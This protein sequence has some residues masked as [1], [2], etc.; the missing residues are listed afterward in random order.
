MPCTLVIRR[1]AA[2]YGRA[3]SRRL[4][5]QRQY[6]QMENERG[7]SQNEPRRQPLYDD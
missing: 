1:F 7:R 4:S 6:Q 3:G 5:E 2:G